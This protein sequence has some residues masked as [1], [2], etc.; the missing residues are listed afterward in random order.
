MAREINYS[1]RDFASLR[2]EQIDYIKRYYPDLLENF[3]DGSIMSVF[4]DL[5]AAIADNIH[6]HIDRTLHETVAEFA[7]QRSSLYNIAATYGL[8]L[9]TKS[10]AV[11]VVELTIKVP[12][13]G[14]AEDKRYLPVLRSGAR[15]FSNGIPFETIY[16][17]DFSQSIGVTGTLDR[18]KIP[19]IQN[20]T[21]TGYFIT[22]QAIVVNGSTR[23]FRRTFGNNTPTSFTK[24]ILPDTNILNIEAVI[25]KQGT[26][27]T[28][29][30]TY[31]EFLNENLKWYQVKSLAQPRVLAVD[32]SRPIASD[33]T[34][35]ARYVE[36]EKKFI[37]E[38][39]PE[40]FTVLTFGNQTNEGFDILDDFLDNGKVLLQ[41][42][43]NN[44][45]LGLAPQAN[46]SM[47]IKYRV[48]GGINTNVG[49]N[50]ITEVGDFNMD[51]SGPDVNIQSIVENSLSVNNITPSVGGSDEPTLD[52][53][54]YTIGYNFSAQDRAV[55]LRD[56]ETLI[57]TMPSKFGAP[58]KVGVRQNQNKIE[59]NVLTKNN[60]NKYSNIVN[61]LLLSN[62]AEYLSEYR[63]IND[64]IEI[65]P[66]QILDLSLEID[67]L[68][69][70]DNRVSIMNAIITQVSD[71]F[72]SN[73][74]EMGQNL[75][76]GDIT[77]IVSNISGVY[78]INSL[79]FFNKVGGGYSENTTSQ[80]YVDNETREIDISDGLIYADKN[81]IIQ[82]RFPETDISV[83][84]TTTTPVRNN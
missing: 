68:V 33:G 14:D 52:E 13:F 5:N 42:F 53:L 60:E 59:I 48:G 56:Y 7:Q 29:N 65:N 41:S 63:M 70:P 18:T 8:Q 80:G 20:G 2:Q 4:L 34:L 21:I 39:T 9:P 25:S 45:S 51:I 84:T 67:V 77:R 31:A 11:S 83:K 32:K 71:Y 17:V 15:F 24:I 57:K 55:T 78:N 46:S 50:T 38:Y 76:I 75:N 74:F 79:R 40:G 66:G 73:T 37:K 72:T 35:P 27:Y 69:E 44:P 3:S 49:V 26:N 58:S 54:R 30:P 23:V 19:D 22:K 16:D 61:S 43:L 1:K 64:Y 6:Y 81:Q 10:A 82:L 47:Y 62:I 28:N 12:A 36:T